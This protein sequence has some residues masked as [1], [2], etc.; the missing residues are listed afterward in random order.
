MD[1]VVLLYHA[2]RRI[3]II[4][5][6]MTDFLFFFFFSLSIYLNIWTILLTL[7]FHYFIQIQ[8][9]VHWI[10]YGVYGVHSTD[11]IYPVPCRPWSLRNTSPPSYF[12]FS[13]PPL[14]LLLLLLPLKV[15]RHYSS[16]IWRF[17]GYFCWFSLSLFFSCTWLSY[18]RDVSSS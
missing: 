5:S 7:L 16:V 14:L 2:K 18:S 9:Q 8:I 13:S 10:S 3:S 17:W 11:L 12:P 1:N 4:S 6:E 15:N